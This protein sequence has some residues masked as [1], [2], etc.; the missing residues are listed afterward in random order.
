MLSITQDPY[1]MTAYLGFAEGGSTY[2]GSQITN[3]S[4][5]QQKNADITIVTADGDRVTLSADSERQASYLTYNC[6]ARGVDA[7]AQFQGKRYSVEV[8]R[9]LSITIEGNLSKEELQDIQK[10]IKTIDK[11]MQQVLLGNTENALAMTHDVSS[12]ESISGF[13][14]S[15]EIE[16]A[17][18]FEQRT[19]V[20]T[21]TSFPEPANEIESGLDAQSHDRFSRVTD[22]MMEALKHQGFKSR[23]LIRPLN[24]YFSKLFQGISEKHEEPEKSEK[25]GMAHRIRSEMM[26]RMEREAQE[27]LTASAESE[28]EPATDEPTETVAQATED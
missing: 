24:K 25:M 11:I 28:P 18:S 2:Y 8:N 10:A 3:L 1:T 19:M 20:E 17:V 9:E 5:Y 6:L 7:M 16:N 14:A 12:M 15:L 26:E 21:Q 4:S 22:K 13:S 27:E 23:K